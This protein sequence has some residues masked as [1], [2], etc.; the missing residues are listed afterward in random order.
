MNR[1]KMALIVIATLLIIAGLYLCF[2]HDRIFVDKIDESRLNKC[3]LYVTIFGGD[4]DTIYST[5]AEINRWDYEKTSPGKLISSNWVIWKMSMD[6]E[7]SITAIPWRR[8]YYIAVNKITNEHLRLDDQKYESIGRIVD[9]KAFSAFVTDP[10]N[11]EIYYKIVLGLRNII[12]NP[13]KSKDELVRH[14]ADA[15]HPAHFTKEVLQTIEKN[16]LSGSRWYETEKYFEGR[17]VPWR[18]D[19]K[20]SL[21]EKRIRINK[22]NGRVEVKSTVYFDN[23]LVSL[24]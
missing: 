10:K 17:Y 2:F 24:N 14:V 9:T 18:E 6:A 3:R 21:V 16:K 20:L 22:T 8:V 7:S 12:Y 15:G 13:F 11:A 1:K 23:V 19:E 5:S 4:V